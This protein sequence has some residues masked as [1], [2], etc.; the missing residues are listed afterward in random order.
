[1]SKQEMVSVPV[2]LVREAIH[3]AECYDRKYPT[4]GARD[5]SFCL[6]AL[7]LEP[8]C[9]RCDRCGKAC[10]NCL[11]D[12]PEDRHT[13]ASEMYAD[14]RLESCPFCGGPAVLLA[15]DLAMCG[16]REC[17]LSGCTMKPDEWNTRA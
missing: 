15:H 9:P 11:S 2:V 17:R 12:F 14:T 13:T 1:M 8:K 16:D 10:L 5:V 4:A 6:T 7:L 3:Y